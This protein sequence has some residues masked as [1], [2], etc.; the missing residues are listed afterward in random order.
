MTKIT[1]TRCVCLCQLTRLLICRSLLIKDVFF[2]PVLLRDAACH[3]GLQDFPVQTRSDV[4]CA[5]PQPGWWRGFQTVSQAGWWSKRRLCLQR[6]TFHLEIRG[7]VWDTPVG[8]IISTCVLYLQPP[9]LQSFSLSQ[10][11]QWGVL[12]RFKNL[13][14]QINATF[15]VFFSGMSWE[16]MR[17]TTWRSLFLSIMNFMS[18]IT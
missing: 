18:G 5:G 11:C 4:C 1:I 9:E 3:A 8:K 7:H 15:L 16:E 14:T 2:S 13:W 17:K 10:L 12:K 6:W